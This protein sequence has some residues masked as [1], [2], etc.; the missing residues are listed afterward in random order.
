M[1]KSNLLIDIIDAVQAMSFELG[2]RVEEHSK[3]SIGEDVIDMAE[4][5]SAYIAYGGIIAL[6][7]LMEVING[8]LKDGDI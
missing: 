3:A 8:L 6:H 4:L 5:K 7:D 2:Q 1:K